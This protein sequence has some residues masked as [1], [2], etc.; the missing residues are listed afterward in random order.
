MSLE[1]RNIMSWKTGIAAVLL[2]FFVLLGWWAI[3]Y[4]PLSSSQEIPS[5][6]YDTNHKIIV[7]NAINYD[8]ILVVYGRC[9]SEKHL[10]YVLTITCKVGENDYKKQYINLTPNTGFFIQEMGIFKPGDSG[11]DEGYKILF[12]PEIMATQKAFDGGGVK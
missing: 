9:I 12:E 4:G 6:N 3:F 1:R 2:I 7:Y 11:Y 8:Y 10:E 5:G